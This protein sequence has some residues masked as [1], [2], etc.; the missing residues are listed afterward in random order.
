MR[1]EPPRANDATTISD[2]AMPPAPGARG[3]PMV[4]RLKNAARRERARRYLGNYVSSAVVI[5]IL[6]APFLLLFLLLRG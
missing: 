3:R 1:L 5:L 4:T 2:D 6:L